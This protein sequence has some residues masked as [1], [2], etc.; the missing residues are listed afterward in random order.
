M[1]HHSYTGVAWQFEGIRT[2]KKVDH[3]KNSKQ[4]NTWTIF[5]I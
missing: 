4:F 1:K 5:E 2:G 3:W